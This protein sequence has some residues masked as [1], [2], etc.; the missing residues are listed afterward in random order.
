MPRRSR[1]ATLYRTYT[2]RTSTLYI[3]ANDIK[4]TNRKIFSYLQYGNDYA[5]DMCMYAV[6]TH[7][8]EWHVGR[9]RNGIS[10]SSW[11]VCKH[12]LLGGLPFQFNVRHILHIQ[13]IIYI[14]INQWIFRCNLRNRSTMVLIS[15]LKN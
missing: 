9:Q 5:V 4:M 14:H 1:K 13:Y 12:S 6:T 3:L 10:R 11:I 7:F 15:E 8:L 2:D